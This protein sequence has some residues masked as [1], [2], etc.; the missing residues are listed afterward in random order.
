VRCKPELIAEHPHYHRGF[1]LALCRFDI[2]SFDFETGEDEPGMLRTVSCVNQLISAEVESGIDPGRIVIGG[3]SQGAAISVLTA[4]TDDCK[5]AGVA[6]LSGWVLLRHK[7][8]AVGTRLSCPL[9]THAD[10]NYLAV[11]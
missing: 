11:F 6:C 4:L 7:L 3:F 1:L 9:G 2:Q 8:K 10:P 5:L